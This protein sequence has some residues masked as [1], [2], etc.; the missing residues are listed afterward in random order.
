MRVLI[1]ASSQSARS[2]EVRAALQQ[3]A[4]RTEPQ[5]FATAEGACQWLQSDEGRGQTVAWVGDALTLGLVASAAV[6]ASARV[7]PLTAEP[8]ALTGSIA[9]DAIIAHAKHTDATT[10]VRALR[11]EHSLEAAPR[12]ASSL[13]LGAARD[14]D[15]ALR[16]VQAQRGL[17]AR[18]TAG[19]VETTR[20]TLR[21]KGGAPAVASGGWADSEALPAD[22]TTIAVG[23]DALRF[24]ALTVPRTGRSGGLQILWGRVDLDGVVRAG[25]AALPRA[26]SAEELILATDAELSVDGDVVAAAPGARVRVTAALCDVFVAPSS[27]ASR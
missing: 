11:I 16:R 18:V 4:Q 1:D 20:L 19:V 5:R 27:A 24:G 21:P 10:T 7:V 2:P 8:C 12:L 14:L 23:A 25:L 9:L 3:L 15:S 13:Q 26:L 17:L 6:R 22:P